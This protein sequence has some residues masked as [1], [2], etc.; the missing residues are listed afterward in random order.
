MIPSEILP[1]V[2]RWELNDEEGEKEKVNQGWVQYRKWPNL[3]APRDIPRQALL[4]N[5]LKERL[6]VKDVEDFEYRPKNNHG[7]SSKPCLLPDD[8]TGAKMTKWGE[9][10]D[11]LGV[12]W[13]TRHQA[14]Q[15]T[16][17]LEKPQL[18]KKTK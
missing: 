16:A 9:R 4:H 5:S 1:F 17:D 15:L 7:G 14:W 11:S 10:D 12:E 18:N 8:G 3:F 6:N 13:A 2:P